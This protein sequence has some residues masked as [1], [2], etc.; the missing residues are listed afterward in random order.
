M[1]SCPAEMR[2][3]I[4]SLVLLA[5]RFAQGVGVPMRLGDGYTLPIF[6][7]QPYAHPIH[8][9]EE[10]A[11]MMRWKRWYYAA[12]LALICALAMLHALHLRADFPNHSPWWTDWAK[13]TDEGWYANAAIRAHLLGRWYLPGDFN[14]AAALPCG[15]FWSGFC[16]SLPASRSKRR[17]DLQ[18]HVSSPAW[19]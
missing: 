16:F 3:A 8:S 1:K 14:P 4:G 2:L 11:R 12:W 6:T 10:T 18:L 19:D 9:Y 5:K 15:R 13:Y 17:A 7:G